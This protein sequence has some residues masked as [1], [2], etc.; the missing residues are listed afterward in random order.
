MINASCNLKTNCN[1]G[2][3]SFWSAN[4]AL[5]S[6]PRNHNQPK[7]WWEGSGAEWGQK[8]WPVVE[9]VVSQIS[10]TRSVH[11]FLSSE[12]GLLKTHSCFISWGIDLGHAEVLLSRR[13]SLLG[14]I[15]HSSNWLT[16]GTLN[17]DLLPRGEM[18]CVMQSSLSVPVGSA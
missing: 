11:S 2:E 1:I 16:W 17:V 8:E 5:V 3:A 15:A 18:N 13:L 6:F 10:L 12:Y 14:W 9:A 4:S 7:T